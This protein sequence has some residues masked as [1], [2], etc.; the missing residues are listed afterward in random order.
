MSEKLTPEQEQLVRSKVEEFLPDFLARIER[1]HKQYALS[2]T[3]ELLAKD[4]CKKSDLTSEEERDWVQA[5]SDFV[6]YKNK[7]EIPR[8]ERQ[9]L[10]DDL[11]K[12]HKK[13]RARF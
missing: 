7:P 4:L 5:L 8:G 2:Y 3:I 12:E 6:D 13:R 1:P 9:Q 10:M 11:L